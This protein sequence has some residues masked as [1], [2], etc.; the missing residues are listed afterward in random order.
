[1]TEK[2]KTRDVFE[3][4]DARLGNVEQDLR[5]LRS[6]VRTDIN[7]LRTE[8]YTSS[9]WISGL[10]FVSWLSLIASIWLKP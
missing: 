9:R 8:M 5:G 4:I 1:M 3:Q 2:I 7:A 6:D 10:V